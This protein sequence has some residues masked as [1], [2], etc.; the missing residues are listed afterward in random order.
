[1]LVKRVMF[2]I[3]A[4]WLM[5]MTTTSCSAQ[6]LDKGKLDA[7]FDSLDARQKF[8]GSVAIV[9]D[10][11]IIYER[12]TGYA[13]VANGVRSNTGTKFR[14]GSI[15]KT[16]TATLVLKAVEEKKLT[17]EHPI[18]KWFPEIKH[19]DKIAVKQLLNHSSG[20]H[21]FTDDS[22][23][24]TYHTQPQSG[25]A[26]LERIIKGGSDFEP[27]SKSAYS[28]SNYV[29]LTFILEKVFGSPYPAIL[30][31]YI[32]APLSLKNTSV[33]KKIAVQ[34][35]EALSY[36]YAGNWTP[37][38]ETDMSLPLGA[39]A[40]ISTPA[41]ILLFADALFNGKL[42]TKEYVELMKTMHNGFGLGLLT[43][44]FYEKKSYGHTGG[45]DGFRSIFG[46]IETD[47]TGIAHVAN[48]VNFNTNDISIALLSAATG[49]EFELPKFSDYAVTKEELQQYTGVYA[50]EAIPLKIT[51]S[52][53]NGR[54]TGQ[55][56]GQS[57]FPLEA[58]EKDTFK[59]DGSGLQLIFNPGEETMILKQGGRTFL[60]KK[61]K[62]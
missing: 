6:D 51:I 1:M 49:K 21:S 32:T 35:N 52:V 54:L 38:S 31:K 18:S 22:D 46:Y 17:L 33:G 57:A 12:A 55:A 34:N 45:I 40:I 53:Q 15:T 60:F 39:G 37:E 56:T 14:I 5:T 42:L 19:A 16:F 28:N 59:F 11:K 25:A 10:G 29:L 13:D 48:G 36:K 62:Q 7:Y 2:F 41:D 8:M 3:S 27:G 4:G 30:E 23:Y 58:T 44:P 26:L 9:K 47:N 20:I 24:L 43:F 50:S 61:E